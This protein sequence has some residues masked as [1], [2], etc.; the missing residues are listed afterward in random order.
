M[1]LD[2]SGR[3]KRIIGFPADSA[4]GV[5]GILG[6]LPLDL[7]RSGDSNFR[8][9]SYGVEGTKRLERDAGVL[10]AKSAPAPDPGVEVR[11]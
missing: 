7:G 6:D 1:S 5:D 4:S 9:D 8:S 2:S 11:E 10:L 3:S